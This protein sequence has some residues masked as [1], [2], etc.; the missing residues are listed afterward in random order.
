M[1]EGTIYDMHE[2]LIVGVWISIENTET[3][4]VRNLRTD[5]GGR[6]SASLQKGRYRVTMRLHPGYPFGYEHASFLISSGERVIVNFRPKPFAIVSSIEGG[7]WIERYDGDFPTDATHFIQQ[8]TGAI[9]ELRIQGDTLRTRGQTFEYRFW[10]IASFDRLTLHADKAVF[11]SKKAR[12]VADGHVIF[13]DGI[14]VRRA[15]RVELDLLTG[16]ATTIDE[17]TVKR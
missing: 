15:R 17:T 1:I 16:T 10:V 7:N 6:Y 13:E 4:E 2:A 11:D 9:R 14:R 5:E 12:L 8:P 3:G